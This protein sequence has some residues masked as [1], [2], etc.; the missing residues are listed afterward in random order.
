MRET[1]VPEVERPGEDMV[2]GTH[3]CQVFSDDEERC[4]I[5]FRFILNGLQGRDRIACYSEKAVEEGLREIFLQHDLSYDDCIREKRFTLS[6]TAQAYFENDIFDPDRMLDRLIR[7]HEE[8][9]DSGHPGT[10]V[11]GEMTPAVQHLQ[12]GDRLLEY[13]SRVSLLVRERPIA[14]FCQYDAN[15]FDGA[16]IMDILKVHPLMMVR[17]A[18]VK[19]PFFIP[20]ET[21]LG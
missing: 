17:G 3:I 10:R 1:A 19:N 21:F 7:F 9:I 18:V 4:D 14:A 16:A 5:L 6:G 8:A 15:A 13:E 11:I 12:G 20:P 2:P